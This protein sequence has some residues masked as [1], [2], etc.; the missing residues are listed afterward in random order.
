MLAQAEMLAATVAMGFHGR[1]RAGHGENFWQY[2]QAVPGDARSA[3]DW[4]RSALMLAA[5]E[6]R[7]LVRP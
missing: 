7:R 6:G 1:R 5:A 2:R 3:V 4:R